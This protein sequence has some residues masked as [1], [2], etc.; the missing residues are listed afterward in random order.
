MKKSWKH[1]ARKRF[2]LL[3]LACRQKLE[4]KL[5]LRLSKQ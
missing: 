4:K 5:V 1:N 3:Y 2:M